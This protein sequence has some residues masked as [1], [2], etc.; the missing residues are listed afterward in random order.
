MKRRLKQNHIPPVAMHPG[1]L[2]RNEIKERG[3]KQTDLAD[4]LSISQ[5][6]LNG[7]YERKKE[8]QY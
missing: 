1:E 6:F 8:N 7:L 3:L 2:F 4:K 5:P